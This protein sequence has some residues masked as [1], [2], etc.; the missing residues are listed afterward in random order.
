MMARFKGHVHLFRNYDRSKAISVRGEAGDLQVSL[1]L[2]YER[3]RF[4]VEVNG[5]SIP[6][7][8]ISLPSGPM[9]EVRAALRVV[10]TLSDAR[11]YSYDRFGP[12]LST[13]LTPQACGLH[14]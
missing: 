1:R 13:A 8:L 2:H 6:W 3:G 10:G 7:D 11:L 12:A 14:L 4:K 5:A 9:S